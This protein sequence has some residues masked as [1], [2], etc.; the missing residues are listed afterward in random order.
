MEVNI[1]YGSKHLLWYE[2]T[3]DTSSDLRAWID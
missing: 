1:Y 2:L 3:N